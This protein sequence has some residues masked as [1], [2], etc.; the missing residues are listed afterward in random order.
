MI[1]RPPR[2]TLFPYTTLFRSTLSINPEITGQRDHRQLPVRGQAS[3]TSRLTTNGY[4]YFAWRRHLASAP[5]PR[6][7][8]LSK[9][10]LSCPLPSFR[11][12]GQRRAPD[13]WNLQPVPGFSDMS[14]ICIEQVF[15]PFSSDADFSVLYSQFAQCY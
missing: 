10:G 7:F 14:R 9:S 1:R 4:R 11:H 6:S 8:S 13:I 2:S 5:E 12:A 15:Q 3:S